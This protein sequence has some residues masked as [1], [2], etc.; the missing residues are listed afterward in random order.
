MVRCVRSALSGFCLL[1]GLQAL[2]FNSV[3]L[4]EAPSRVVTQLG[5]EERDLQPP[6]D[7]VDDKADLHIAFG[8]SIAGVWEGSL[9]KNT[10]WSIAKAGGGVVRTGTGRDLLTFVFDAPGTYRVDILASTS[11]D[12]EEREHAPPPGSF[13]VIVGAVRM[14]FDLAH[15]TLSQPILGGQPTDHIELRIPVDVA[16]FG[17]GTADVDVPEAHTAGV[18]TTVIAQPAEPRITLNSGVR[19]MTYRLSGTVPSGSYIMFDLVDANGRIWSWSCKE[20]VR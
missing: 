11:A 1:V 9:Q 3:A 10:G 13:K 8:E 15:A 5:S 16:V 19:T 2:S 17:G 18:G 4:G 12:E 7:V 20:K 14:T 6:T